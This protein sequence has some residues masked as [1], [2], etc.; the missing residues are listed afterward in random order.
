MMTTLF[1][2][3]WLALQWSVV[4]GA[5]LVG[6]AFDARSR[7]IPNWLT[8]PLLLAGLVAACF[9][10][11]G[12]GLADAVAGCLLLAVPYVLLFVFAGGGAGDAKMMGALG[13]WLGI[14]NGSIVLV[15]VALAGG[16]LGLAVTL[17]KR[18]GVIVLNNLVLIAHGLL[19]A[20]LARSGLAGARQSIPAPHT[21]RTMPYGV[22]IL[23]GVGVGALVSN[24]GWT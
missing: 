16:L 9:F 13:A 2:H 17:V 7:R 3:E 12:A 4:I 20:A 19:T 11:G 22:A 1:H 18:E 24:L 14:A 21:M 23:L 8:L 6:A 10:A 15:C 5:S